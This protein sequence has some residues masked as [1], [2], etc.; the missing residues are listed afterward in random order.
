MNPDNP[1][2]IITDPDKYREGWAGGLPETPC[3]FGSKVSETVIQREWLPRMA[4]RHGVHSV[5]D[6][7]AGDLNW[8]QHVDWEVQYT[9]LDLVPRHP[10]V[11]TFDICR[12]VPPTADLALCL[13]VLN[14]LPEADAF[15]A[16][17]NMRAAGFR[18]LAYTWWPGM[19]Q[20]MDLGFDEHVVIRPRIGAELRWLTFA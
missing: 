18:F 6:I 8:M 11:Q 1:S 9:G 16:L 17:D 19:L 5:V 20:S 3:G 12:Q 15:T 2:G 7:G 10:D 14:H 13:W 4:A